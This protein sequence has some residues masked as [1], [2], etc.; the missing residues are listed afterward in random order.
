MVGLLVLPKMWRWSLLPVCLLLLLA[1]V[2]AQTAPTPQADTKTF[3]YEAVAIHPSKMANGMVWNYTDDSFTA[4][5]TTV[6]SLL[7]NAYN[8][9]IDDQIEGLPGWANTDRFDIQGKM[10]TETMEALKKLDREAKG[11]QRS[12]MLQAMLA[13]RFNLKIHHDTKDLPIYALVVAKGGSKLKEAAADANGGYSMG[14]GGKEEFLKGHGVEL[15]SLAY[16]LSSNVGRIILNKTG[17]SG[18]YEI[19]LKWSPQ[20]NPSEDDGPSIFTALQ[21]Q[22]GLKLEPIKAPVESIVIEHVDRP[23]EN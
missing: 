7:I 2:S 1:H 19:D 8:L 3:T 23:T 12:L 17:L 9:I 20:E 21:E 22:L 10:D 5:G 4:T 11:H 15:E 14:F 6:R 13:D 18:K 16:S